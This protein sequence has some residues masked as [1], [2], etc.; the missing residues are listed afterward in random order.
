MSPLAQRNTNMKKLC[1]TFQKVNGWISL[2]VFAILAVFAFGMAT[3]AAPCVQYQDTIDFY[4]VIQPLND[5]IL[6][7]SLGGLALGGFYSVLRNNVRKVFYVSNYVWSFVYVA[8]SIYVAIYVLQVVAIYQS[9]YLTLDFE[10]MNA[11]WATKGTGVTISPDTPVFAL[12]YAISVLVLLSSLP[13]LFV[14]VFKL[15][16]TLRQAKKTRQAVTS[17]SKEESR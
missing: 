7:F 10:A 13:V 15:A 2:A 16:D 3:P 5:M 4:S 8:F 1:G 11:Y 6:Y 14:A 12:G 17:V 9:R